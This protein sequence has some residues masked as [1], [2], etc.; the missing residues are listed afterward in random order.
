V[1]ER[2]FL[3]SGSGETAKCYRA[4]AA[5]QARRDRI[6]VATRD[7]SRVIEMLKAELRDGDVVLIKAAPTSASNDRPRPHRP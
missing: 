2:A 4:G 5:S 1:A 7:V 3:V 6:T